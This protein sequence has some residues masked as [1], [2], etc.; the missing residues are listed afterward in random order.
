MITH[1]KKVDLL[2]P[3]VKAGAT[4]MAVEITSIGIQIH[5]GMGY[6][7]ETGAAQYWRDARILPIYEGTNGIQALDLMFRKTLRDQGSTVRSYLSDIQQLIHELDQIPTP[8]ILNVRH[9]LDSALQQITN[10]LSWIDDPKNQNMEVMAG[11]ATTYLH[12]FSL[13]A[14]GA[15]M[16][17]SAIAA[18]HQIQTGQGNETFFKDKI[19]TACFYATHLLPRVQGLVETIKTGTSSILTAN[20]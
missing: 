20:F 17:K 18:Y 16:A 3:I 8:E 12:A 14:G 9:N 10:A 5:G 13:T 1:K 6:I 19:N 7:E 11:A 2:T 4:D 15:M